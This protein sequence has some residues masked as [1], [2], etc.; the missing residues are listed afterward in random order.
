MDYTNKEYMITNA[1]TVWFH[2]KWVKNIFT[3]LVESVS[4]RFQEI[5]SA[6]RTYCVTLHGLFSAYKDIE[7]YKRIVFAREF[8]FPTNWFTQN[9]H[10][11]KKKS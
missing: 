9:Y 6:K 3:K 1:I 5:M 11:K 10:A 4:K 8:F 7:W 2:D